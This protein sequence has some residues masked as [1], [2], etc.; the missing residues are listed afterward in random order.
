MVARIATALLAGL[1]A[2]LLISGVALAA[3]QTLSATLGPEGDVE[4][5]ASGSATIVIDVDAGTACWEMS[6]ENLEDG[7]Q[8]TVSHIHE[9]AVGVS[10]GVV[11]DLDLEL[12]GT[13]FDSEGC[14]EGVDADVL[15]AIVDAPAG[16]YVNVHSEV[17][18]P[19][20]IRGQ[21]AAVAVDDDDDEATDDDATTPDTAVAQPGPAPLAL[22]G[23]LLL[24][25]GMLLAL[26]RLA[27]RF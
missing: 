22:T 17:N 12:S 16:Y 21:L 15:Q 3:E 20:V 25:I 27:V 2:T 19:G 10:G 9:G 11:V 7:D 13:E 4:T 14:T 1:L 23:V 24:G 18:P 8:F 5:E 6:A 26:R